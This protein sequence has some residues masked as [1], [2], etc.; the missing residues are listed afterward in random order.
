MLPR[1]ITSTRAPGFA[2]RCGATSRQDSDQLSLAEAIATRSSPGGSG[3]SIASA[4]GTRTRS[5]NSPP[6]APPIGAPNIAMRGTDVQCAVRPARQ[7]SHSPHE[8]AHG[9]T[10]RSPGATCVIASPTSATRA[11]HSWPRANGGGIGPCPARIAESTSHDV[12]ATAG[13]PCSPIPCAHTASPRP[14]QL[15]TLVVAAAE[16]AV[17][18]C[19]AQRST[20][21]LDRVAAQLEDLLTEA[22]GD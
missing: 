6:Q 1:A 7:R 13:K 17:A 14:G 12:A 16:G 20:E 2:R 15:A 4:H 19:R 5:E 9:T 18:M 8:I 3:T 21:P 10:T 11:T 22:A